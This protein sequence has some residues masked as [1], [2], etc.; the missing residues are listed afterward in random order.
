MEQWTL[1]SLEYDQVKECLKEQAATVLG[2]EKAEQLMPDASIER[3]KDRLDSTREGMD[4]IRLKGDV[5]FG[6]VR[7]LRTPIRRAEMKGMLTEAEC[8]DIAST[9]SAGR[10]IKSFLRQIEEEEA[11][12]PILRG[13]AEQVESLN[14]VEKEILRTIDEQ[15]VVKDQASSGLGKI[16]RQIGEARKQINQTL[17][18]MIRN[19]HYTKMMQEAIITQ[20]FD[21]YVIPVKMEYRSRFPGI[22]HD[23]SS[24][25]ATLFIEPEAVVKWNNR[26][27]ELELA[28]KKEVEKV[29]RRLTELIGEETESL[30]KNTEILA[31]LDLIMACAR[32]GYQVKGVVPRISGSLLSLKKARHPLINAEDVVPIDLEM[33]ESYQAII[34][35]GPNTGGKTVTLKTVG[36]FALMTQSGIP[37][38]A[39]EES[40]MPVFSGVYADI[41][42]EQSIEQNLSTFSG[43]LT[44]II[45][46]LE[47]IDKKSL[48]LFDELGAGTDPAEGAALAISILEH[49]IGRGCLVMATTHYSELKLFAHTHPKAIN[50]SVEFDVKTLKPTFRLLIGVPGSSNAFAISKRL[51]LRD[52]LIKR[53]KAHLSTD[54]NRMEEMITS[55]TEDRKE[56]EEDRDQAGRIRKEAEA[57][58]QDLKQKWE[59]LEEEKAR[60]KENARREAQ[61]IIKRAEREAEEVLKQLQSWIK[62][63]PQDLKEHELIEARSRLK[64]AVPEWEWAQ[65]Q[66]KK[67][68]KKETLRVGNEVRVLSVNQ[69]GTIVDE[70]GDGFFQVQVGFLKMK[71]HK[72]QLEKRSSPKPVEA[73]KMR[74]TVKRSTADVKPE[75]DLRGKLVEEALIEIDNYLDK[76]ILAGYKQV[77]L[78]HGKGTGALRSG[79]QEYLQRQRHVKS[80]RLGN[81]GEGGSGVT[82]VELK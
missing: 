64:N 63:R 68:G 37:I 22:V 4:V 76:A 65:K 21:R 39:E 25:G 77:F 32:Y 71:I 82:V 20:R 6:G 29:L 51:G 10:K 80:F 26:L 79:V 14:S 54:E 34:I 28:E 67:T 8:L 43:H 42:D 66:K 61:A 15:A 55:L 48:V 35:T 69:T 78:I 1:K 19:S 31:E 40:V 41:G 16:R 5:P 3:V 70:L 45:Q 12:L 17:Q 44:N 27:R 47:Q 52:E 38:P 57:L 60:I 46:I 23:Q 59:Q 72:D 11:P 9:I 56:A 62:A 36:L 81:H 50:A 33:G 73:E 24:S 49:V 18:D 13:L 53:A 7:D 30:Q 74:T 2:K 75:C 58:Y